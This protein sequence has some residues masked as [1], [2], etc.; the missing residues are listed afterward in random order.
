M[1]RPWTRLEHSLLLLDGYL[2]PRFGTRSLPELAEDVKNVP[3]GYDVT[4]R[5][6][7][8]QRLLLLPNLSLPRV[9]LEAYDDNIKRHLDVVNRSRPVAERVVLK[10]F[11]QL[12]LLYTEHVLHRFFLDRAAFLADLNAIVAQWNQSIRAETDRFPAV[13]ANDLTKLAYWMATGSGKTL[14]LHINYHQFLHYS[15][16]AGGRRLNSILLI[17]PNTGLSDQ[18]LEELAK[19]GI[20]AQRFRSGGSA[21]LDRNTVQVLEITKLSERS[22]GPQTVHV[23]S[24]EGNNLVF[25]DEGHRG[26]SGDVW[27]RLR[28]TVAAEGFTFEYSAT[29]GEAFN[30]SNKPADFALRQSYGK[31]IVFDYR[32]KYF[33]GDGYGKDYNLL[34]L[35][36]GYDPA[37][38]DVLLMGNLLAFYEQRRLYGEL[39]DALRPYHVEPPL[40]VFIGHTVQTGKSKSD[41][42]ANDKAS[43]SDVLSMVRFLQRV[44]TNADGWAVATIDRI[45]AGRSDLKDD[46]GKDVFFDKLLTLK[47]LPLP[48]AALYADLLVQVFHAAAPAGLHLANLRNAPGEIGV[49]TGNSDTYFAVINIGDDA[50]FMKMAE[51]AQLGL[52]TESEAIR[53]SLFGV[54]NAPNSPVNLLIGAKKFTEGWNSWRVSAMGLLNVGRSEGS[55]IIQMFGRGVRL[56]GREFSLKRSSVLDG[57]HPPRIEMLE[58]LNIFSINGDY[59]AEFKKMLEREGIVEGY[60]EIALPI[61]YTLFDA[62]Q[63]KLLTLRLKHDLRFD[64]QPA[65]GAKSIDHK[66]VRP[67]VDLRPVIQAVSSRLNEATAL[68]DNTPVYLDELLPLDLLDWEAIYAEMLAWKRQRGLVNLLIERSALRQV[69]E[70]R[71]YE[72]YAPPALLQRTSFPDLARLQQIVVVILKSYAERYY[73]LQRKVWESK[74]LEYRRLDRS[75]DNLR[76]TILADGRAGYVVKVNRNKPELVEAVRALIEEG[77]RLYRQDLDELPNVYFDRHLY[78]PLLAAGYYDGAT[79]VE[80]PDIQRGDI[81]TVPVVLNRG[82]AR[83]PRKLREFLQAHPATLGPRR[84]YLLRN[85][86]RGKGIGFFAADDFYPDFILWLVDGSRQRIVFVD[87]KGLALLKPNNFDHPKI[88]LYRTLQEIA[89][90]LGDPNVGL[91]SFIISDKSFSKTQPDFGTLAHSREEFHA[92]HVIFPEDSVGMILA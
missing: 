77:S 82:E 75:D 35:P 2:H 10:Y 89:D 21:S 38:G 62:E 78:Q 74:N 20:P 37:Y 24:F 14:L 13:S 47:H 40:L 25:V 4:G 49:R 51:E 59:L 83:F 57:S 60:D 76:P 44:A 8:A 22:A 43:L 73:N 16:L 84:L 52:A 87:P 17:T 7:V 18:H 66:D 23:E 11:Q 26:A 39:G 56:K 58:T 70:E 69:L 71:R 63:P 88:Q 86:S 64:Q 91:D 5:S 28:D 46:T 80:S 34:N 68:T 27:M 65:F 72:L 12:A 9:D 54:I 45:L 3:E 15:T 29:F 79:F 19:S 55:E 90:N 6:Y 53:G 36:R 48:A 32:Y 85:L 92:H 42:T 81:K 30:G 67:I 41:L 31:S 61:Q 50:N 1:A 33:H